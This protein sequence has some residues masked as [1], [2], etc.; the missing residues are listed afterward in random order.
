MKKIGLLLFALFVGFTIQ[1][2][3]SDD[4][5]G[6]WQPSEGTSYVKIEKEGSKYYGKVVWLK[7]PLDEKGSPKTDKKNSD[8]SLQSRP[9]KGLRMLADFTFDE[10]SKE[11]KNGTIYDPKNG[12]KY[13]CTIKRKSKNQLEVRGSLDQTGLVGRTDVW[14]KVEKKK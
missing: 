1:A 5:V 7:E 10:K 4:L 2:Q 14:V 3:S 9:V 11:W 8:R 12:N 6:V 13:Y